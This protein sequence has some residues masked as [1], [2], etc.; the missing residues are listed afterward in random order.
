M[1]RSSA[2]AIV[3]ASA[4]LASCES[5]P[6]APADPGV[7]YHVVQPKDGPIRYNKI[8]DN[9]T[10]LEECAARLEEVRLRFLRAGGGRTQITGVY[11][12]TYVFVDPQGVWVSQTLDGG[13]FFA[14]ARTGDGRL[15]IPGAIRRVPSEPA[16]AAEAEA[17]PPS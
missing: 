16:P 13:R 8:A 2:V 9:Q 11:Q 7:C 5:G 3:I 12:G 15:A 1:I 6:S 17:A 14:M 10:T 4:A